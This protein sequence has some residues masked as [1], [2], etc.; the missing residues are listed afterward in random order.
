MITVM[1]SMWTCHS[2]SSPTANIVSALCFATT[3]GLSGLDSLLLDARNDCHISWS[4]R[5][6]QWLYCSHWPRMAPIPQPDW[7]LR[8]I[9]VQYPQELNLVV[10]TS[11]I[12]WKSEVWFINDFPNATKGTR[13]TCRSIYLKKVWM[14]WFYR[15]REWGSG[16]WTRRKQP[17]RLS[18]TV[19]Q[20]KWSISSNIPEFPT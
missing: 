18:S 3:S 5:Y 13:W 20:I 10:L 19:L 4:Q 9:V 6:C 8:P 17:R 14:D 15:P 1:F 12:H 16:G 11:S 7:L 2:W